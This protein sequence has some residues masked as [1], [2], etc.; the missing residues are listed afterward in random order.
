MASKYGRGNIIYVLETLLSQTLPGTS[1]LAR[2][3]LSCCIIWQRQLQHT[4][5]LVRSSVAWW[6]AQRRIKTERQSL[7][8]AL[9]GVLSPVCDLQSA[10]FIASSASVSHNVWRNSMLLSMFSA[11]AYVI[12]I[13]NLGPNRRQVFLSYIRRL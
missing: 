5:P 4:Q 7:L 13:Q 3:F 10:V 11:K 1:Q 2:M 12:N 6:P 8:W 9:W